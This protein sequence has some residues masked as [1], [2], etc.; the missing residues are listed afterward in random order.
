MNAYQSWL[1]KIRKRS[2]PSGVISQWS[3]ELVRR[4]G[5]DSQIWREHLRSI[6]DGEEQASPELILDLDLISAPL[7]ETSSDD[8]FQIPLWE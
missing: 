1:T 6:L 8:D 2:Q 5:G 4:Q 7:R 3:E